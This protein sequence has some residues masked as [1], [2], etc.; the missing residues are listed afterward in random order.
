MGQY[1]IANI[2]KREILDPNDFG[3]GIELMEWSYTDD[4]TVI[5]MTNLLNDRWKGDQV[6]VIGDYADDDDPNEPWYNTMTKLKKELNVRNLYSWACNSCVA[7]IPSRKN[8][9]KLGIKLPRP[10]PTAKDVVADIEDHGFRYIINGATMQYVDLQKC[11][12]EW[13][14]YNP[15]TD[16]SDIT[17]ISPLSLLL[18]IGNGR[19][20]GDYCGRNGNLVGSWCETSR[21]ITVAK[22]LPEGLNGFTEL[23]PEFT[24]R[25]ELIPYTEAERVA[26]EERLRVLSGM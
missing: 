20:G 10:E 14:W 26:E 3:R 13:A 16:S 9:K 25:K 7:I 2:D 1:I 17:R 8:C 22:E 15:Q 18:A 21:S 6:V 19:G 23:V 4:R 11:P 5:A 24:E 12:I